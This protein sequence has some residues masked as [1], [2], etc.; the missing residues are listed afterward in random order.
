MKIIAKI[1]HLQCAAD[2]RMQLCKMTRWQANDVNT[3]AGTD[4]EQIPY[5]IAEFGRLCKGQARQETDRGL[6]YKISLIPSIK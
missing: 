6:K 2:T 1:M 5:L 4:S 3:M